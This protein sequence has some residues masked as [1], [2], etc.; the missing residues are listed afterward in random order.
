MMGRRK[1]GGA[2]GVTLVGSLAVV[3]AVTLASRWV[4]A[5]QM[6]SPARSLDASAAALPQLTR[7]DS[8]APVVD[9]LRAAL[10]AYEEVR[11]ELAADRLEGV[12]ASASRLAD[13]LRIALEGRAGLAGPIPS[14]IE[15]AARA[16]ESMAEAEDLAAARAAFGEVSRMLL[17]LA[18][19]DPR[20]A[21]GWHVFACPM[22][23]TFDRWMQPTERLQ[24][25]YMGP[26]M[27][28]CG[29]PADRSV[30]AP[31]ASEQARSPAEEAGSP[32]GKEASAAEPEFKPG[33]AGLKMADVRDHKHLWRDIEEL[34]VWER[35]DRI[36]VAEYR[37]K[38][39][40]KTAHFLGFGGAAADEFA[41]A[42]SE[43][44]ASIRES[45]LARRATAGDGVGARFSSDLRA[46]VT[47]VTSLL[48]EDPRHQ[49][50]APTCKKWLLKL[51]FGPDEAKEASEAQQVQAGESGRS[52]S[53]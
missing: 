1:I 15:G 12:P 9:S 28:A 6:R 32:E 29:S 53:G 20:L 46:A 4:G 22:T 39:I 19:S 36:S 48:R 50:F 40:E 44:V 34:Q 2:K 14:A 8:P 27:S 21:E 25:P 42:A 16:A 11:G 7:Q 31:S 24:N 5:E 18:D 45:F 23:E 51:A 37:G 13:A 26:A 49:L 41:A 17:L 30:P 52:A 43:A 47:R 33:I 38:V 10:G 3:A 35:G